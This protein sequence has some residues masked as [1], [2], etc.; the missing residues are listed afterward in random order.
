[1]TE[2][3]Q[4]TILIKWVRSGIG[5]TRRQKGMVRSLGLRRLNQIVERVDSP[6]VRGLVAR[7]PHLVEIVD[8]APR[9]PAWSRVAEYTLLPKEVVPPEPAAEPE[10]VAPAQEEIAPPQPVAE[11]PEEAIAKV[12]QEAPAAPKEARPAKAAEAAKSV[13]AV[14]AKGKTAKKGEKKKAKPVERSAKP[15]KGSKK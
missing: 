7:I 11:A 3:A 6:Q 10:A 1:M 9:P 12:S 14:A 2:K 5:F 4:R 15:S 8:S 13:K